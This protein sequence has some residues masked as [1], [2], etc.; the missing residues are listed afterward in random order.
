MATAIKLEGEEK[1]G[2]IVPC[3]FYLYTLHIGIT[4][5]KCFKPAWINCKFPIMLGRY[6]CELI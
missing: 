1:K 2:G 6:S 3:G 4:A 5:K